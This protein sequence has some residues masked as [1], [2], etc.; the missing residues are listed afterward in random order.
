MKQIVFV[1]YNALDELVAIF[2]DPDD[3]ELFASDYNLYIEQHEVENLWPIH[4][5]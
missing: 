3:A 1:V 5:S 4:A 2:V